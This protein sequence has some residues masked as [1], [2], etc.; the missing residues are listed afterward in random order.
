MSAWANAAAKMLGALESPWQGWGAP[1]ARSCFGTCLWMDGAALVG[2]CAAR[3]S[4]NKSHSSALSS[5][6]ESV[7]K[8]L[9]RLVRRESKNCTWYSSLLPF[10]LKNVP[11]ILSLKITLRE[12]DLGGKDEHLEVRKWHIYCLDALRKWPFIR[13]RI[14]YFFPLKFCLIQG[15]DWIY[16][17]AELKLHWQRE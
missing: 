7:F 5:A 16:Q 14:L 12:Y 11:A 2:I 6:E 1:A 9:W 3:S 10:S 8:P 15:R 17:W 13:D 4:R